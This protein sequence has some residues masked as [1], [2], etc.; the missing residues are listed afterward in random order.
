MA[1]TFDDGPSPYTPQIIQILLRMHVPAT[2]FA[3]GQQLNDF[4]QGLREEVRHGFVIGDHTENHAWLAHLPPAAQYGQI[5]DAAIRVQRLGAPFPRLFRPPY[6]AFNQQTLATLH[7]LKMLMVL[8][9]IDT[10]DWKRPGVGPIVTTALAG[11][12]PGAIVLMHDGGGD[13]SE[14]VAALPQL[15]NGLRKRGYQLVTVPELAKLDPPPR[16]QHF[17]TGLFGV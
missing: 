12:S 17:P 5:R 10:G 11:A 2:F 3:V 13:R 14:T 16:H 8:W 7:G 4:A 15:I 1:L 6:G 9:S